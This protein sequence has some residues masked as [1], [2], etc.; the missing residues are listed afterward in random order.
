MKQKCC[1]KLIYQWNI[2]SKVDL[3]SKNL[4]KS[5]FIK[6]KFNQKLIY[7]AK[8]LSTIDLS[9]KNLVK[10]WFIHQK[11]V[12]KSTYQ[13][14]TKQYSI[15]INDFGVTLGS[16]WGHFGVTLESSWFINQKRPNK[17][18]LWN[19]FFL[20]PF[21]EL[22]APLSNGR[23]LQQFYNNPKWPTPICFGW[24]MEL[25]GLQGRAWKTKNVLTCL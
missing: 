12:Q 10:S 22:L 18:P 9:S 4:V 23:F 11:F 24:C 8:I 6:Q 19:W 1:Q 2:W 5:W 16:L 13:Q 25:H 7:E 21:F 14:K 17:K 15:N 3:S 20:N